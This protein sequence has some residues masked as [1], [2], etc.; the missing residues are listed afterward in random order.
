MAPEAP[1]GM[2]KSRTGTWLKLWTVQLHQDWKLSGVLRKVI[3]FVGRMFCTAC[4]KDATWITLII[5]CALY[6]FGRCA[7][8]MHFLCTEADSGEEVAKIGEQHGV[9]ICVAQILKWP[10]RW[11]NRDISLL[12]SYIMEC[13]FSIVFFHKMIQ[14][15]RG[16]NFYW[17]FMH[18]FRIILLF[19]FC[20]ACLLA[21]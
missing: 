20:T 5:V 1:F 3:H 9:E 11:W 13:N 21:E 16:F 4:R 12:I 17:T 6:F 7:P 8:C 18:T 19:M 2:K 15:M 14:V 10:Q